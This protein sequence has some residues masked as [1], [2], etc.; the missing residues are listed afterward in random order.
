[1]N[2]FQGMHDL[3]LLYLVYAEL[4][5]C[6]MLQILIFFIIILVKFKNIL[7]LQYF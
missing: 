1:M 4:L 5:L 2:N 6:F 3:P 7:T